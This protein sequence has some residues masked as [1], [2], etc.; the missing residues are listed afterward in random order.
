MSVFDIYTSEDIN[1]WYL[2]RGRSFSIELVM[3]VD[4]GDSGGILIRCN[5]RQPY[6]AGVYAE[7]LDENCELQIVEA[8]TDFDEIDNNDVEEFIFKDNNRKLKSNPEFD[9]KKIE[10]IT[11]GTVLLQRTLTVGEGP[12]PARRIVG[13]FGAVTKPFKLAKEEDYAIIMENLDP[14]DPTNI[15]IAVEVYE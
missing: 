6:L 11:G 5:N 13:G 9:A 7:T 1:K 8:P 3:E 2:D 14:A 4:G 15:V 10:G 12:A